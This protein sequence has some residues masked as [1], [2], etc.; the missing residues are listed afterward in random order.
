MDH[1]EPK[2]RMEKK[3]CDK[4]RDK[5]RGPYTTK[6]V[7]IQTELWGRTHAHRGTD[8]GTEAQAQAQAHTQKKFTNQT[9]AMR[10]NKIAIYE[11]SGHSKT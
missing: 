10:G 2:T 11:P 5:G 7:R 9:D 1:K 8:T 4:G 6:H 3:G